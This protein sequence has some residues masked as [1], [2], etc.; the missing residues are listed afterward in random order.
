MIIAEFSFFVSII[1]QNVVKENLPFEIGFY[2]RGFNIF[3]VSSIFCYSRAK[4]ED[5]NVKI[6]KLDMTSTLIRIVFVG[7]N[8]II[9]FYSVSFIPISIAYILQYSSPVWILIL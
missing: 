1:F 7:I 2:L 3:I 6:H 8:Q 5:R 9:F 4:E